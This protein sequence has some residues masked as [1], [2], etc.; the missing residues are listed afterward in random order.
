MIDAMQRMIR[1]LKTGLSNLV[2]R[3][4]VNLVDDSKKMQTLQLSVLTEETREGV[5]RAQNYGF[6]SVPLAGAE[7]VV[8][9]VGG[10]RE[11]GL[12]VAVDDRRYRL[13]GLQ[14]GEVALY[15]KDGASVVMKADGSIEVTPKPG[16][17]VKLAGETDAALKGDAY[18]SAEA[19]FLDALTTYAVAIKAVADPLNA[20][21]PTLTA[22]ITAFKAAG[23][24]AKSTKVKLS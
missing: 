10:R 3:A 4:V 17:V 22:A 23:T 24:S 13:T 19:T 12:A 16:A 5:E 21:T 2:A 14:P 11:H 6:T 1:P 20:A 15:H 8:L 9:F 7:A 18:V